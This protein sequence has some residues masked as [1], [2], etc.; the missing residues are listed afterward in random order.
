M[1]L[2]I[3][4]VKESREKVTTVYMYEDTGRKTWGKRSY[5]CAFYSKMNRPVVA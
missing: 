1:A 4:L 3:K 2:V 5:E